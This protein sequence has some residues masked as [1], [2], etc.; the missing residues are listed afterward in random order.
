MGYLLVVSCTVGVLDDC[1]LAVG[2]QSNCLCVGGLWVSC[3]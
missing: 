1:G 2:S 3:W